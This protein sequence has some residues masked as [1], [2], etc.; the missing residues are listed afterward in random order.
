M[1]MR[2]QAGINEVFDR[3]H[4]TETACEVPL[5]LA[6]VARDAATRGNGVYRPF[7]ETNFRSALNALH[8]DFTG[9]TFVDIGSGKGKQLLIA[10]DY[11]FR[12]IIGIEFAPLLHE[13]ARRNVEIYRGEHQKCCDITPILEDALGYE[14]P[15]GPVVCTFLNSMDASTTAAV[16]RKIGLKARAEERPVFVVYANMRRVSEIGDIFG[17]LEGLQVLQRSR[18]HVIIG[19]KCAAQARGRWPIALHWRAVLAGAGA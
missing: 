15:S 17:G 10:S 8:I 6:G 1:R 3:R 12:K 9:Y 19:N 4:G 5:E 7:W 13:I 2:R 18:R 11:P 14:L 16:L